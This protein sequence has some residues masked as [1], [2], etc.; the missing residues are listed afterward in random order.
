MASYVKFLESAYTDVVIPVSTFH[1]TD[2][3][4]DK[5]FIIAT[6]FWFIVVSIL[7]LT[8][9]S[10]LSNLFPKW[11]ANL[12][13]QKQK[14]FPSYGIGLMHHLVIS[15]YLCYHLLSDLVTFFQTPSDMIA[16]FRFA[17]SHYDNVYWDR[18]VF[19]FTLGF[20]IADTLFYS[21][22]EAVR[23]APL[24]LLHHTVALISMLGILWFA[25]GPTTQLFI[26]MMASEM[27]SIFFNSAWILRST[28]FRGTIL[29][30][31]LEMLFVV[32]FFLVRNVSMSVLYYSVLYHLPSLGVVV[33]IAV[34]IGVLLQ[35]YWL[36]KIAMSLVSPRAGKNKTKKS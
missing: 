9:N 6:I 17:S 24:Y 30:S 26:V 14:E 3:F 13:E 19:P 36:Y 1:P 12:P 25:Q 31:I 27:S 29:V 11:Y 16:T 7:Q 20:F 15:P 32:A 23:G 35:F 18:G 34:A 2:N 10:M 21:I 8:F 5:E 33:N 22:P 4:F 28:G